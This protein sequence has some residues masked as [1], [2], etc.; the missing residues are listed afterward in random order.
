YQTLESVLYGVVVFGFMIVAALLPGYLQWFVLRS[1]V[2]KA[3]WWI[4]VPLLAALMG[5]LPTVFE[6]VWVIFVPRPIPLIYSMDLAVFGLIASAATQ[7]I[8][9]CLLDKNITNLASSSDLSLAPD[10]ASYPENR[11]LAKKLYT[12]ISQTWKTDLDPAMGRL[13]YLVGVDGAGNLVGY[14]AV[15]PTSA[16]NVDQTP[17]PKLLKKMNSPQPD[18]LEKLAKFQVAFAPP[19]TVQI[20][21]W[22]GIPLL[23][24]GIATAIVV[25][26]FSVL[27][28]FI[29]LPPL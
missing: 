16:K 26:T 8:C 21:S 15:T 10:L 20:Q 13:D 4:L 28:R 22:R 23:W 29:L 1:R 9:F 25:L 2:A 19:G 18:N 6:I 12:Q 5:G 24:L 3:R 27:A 14:E 11:T 7:A 17:L